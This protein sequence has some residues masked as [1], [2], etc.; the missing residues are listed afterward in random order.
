VSG[1]VSG[2]EDREERAVAEHVVDTFEPSA[3]VL[4]ELE[5]LKRLPSGQEVVVRALGE[6]VQEDG[7]AGEGPGETPGSWLIP[8]PTRCTTP[9]RPA[10]RRGPPPL[11]GTSCTDA[12]PHPPQADHS[13]R[14][15]RAHRPPAGHRRHVHPASVWAR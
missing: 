2:G 14:V 3:R 4:G 7:D 13:V 6:Q 8:W 10:P 12:R 11:L 9:P 5:F 1:G 15:D